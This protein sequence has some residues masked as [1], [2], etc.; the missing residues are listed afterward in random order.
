[1]SDPKYIKVLDQIRKLLALATSPNEHEAALAL[2][3]AKELML[4]YNI[5]NIDLEKDQAEDIIEV[6]FQ[7]SHSSEESSLRFVYWLGKAFLVKPILI[8]RNIGEDKIKFEKYIRFIGKTADV[9]VSTYIFSYMMSFLDKKTKEYSKKKKTQKD[10]SLG[11]IT[12]VCDKLRKMEELR[13]AG[14]TF[15]EEHPENALVVTSNALINSY[16]KDKYQDKLNEGKAPEIESDAW[17]YLNGYK[18]GE[19]QGIFAGVGNDSE[20]KIDKTPKRLYC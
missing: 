12:A 3:K 10:Y 7:I 9:A 14:M 18:A 2:S 1:M 20:K 17:D 16:L 4:R 15:Y 11:F 6:D 19:K 5:D 13:T 8:K